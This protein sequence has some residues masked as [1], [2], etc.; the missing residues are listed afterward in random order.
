[1]LDAGHKG[2]TVALVL[3]VGCNVG[4]PSN[5]FGVPTGASAS[6]SA[7][8][9]PTSGGSD[10]TGSEGS[11]SGTAGGTAD[12]GT[13]G[14]GGS[15]GPG[16]TTGMTAASTG[17]MPGDSSSGGMD[18]GTEQPQSGMYSEC[19]MPEDCIV[20]SNVCLTVNMMSGFCTNMGCLDPVADCDAT[21]GGTAVPI[22]FPVELDKVE[23]DS[24]ALDCSAG[25]ICPTGMVCVALADGSICA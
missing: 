5:E 18:A 23:Q 7:T 13:S 9:T 17:A 6:A 24:C 4:N 19:A 3:L 2:S 8:A 25:Q 15:S 14:G 1:M 10:D 12:D 21:P 22:C 11:D 16:P 20:P